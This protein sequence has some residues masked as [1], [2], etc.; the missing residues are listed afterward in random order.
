M[1]QKVSGL[2]LSPSNIDQSGPALVPGFSCSQYHSVRV[3][4]RLTL[5]DRS[6]AP[7]WLRP[8]LTPTPRSC[9]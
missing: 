5:P 2:F 7:C 3:K 9:C 6:R 1:R 4:A 8:A